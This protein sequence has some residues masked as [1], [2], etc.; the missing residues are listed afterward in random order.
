MRRRVAATVGDKGG[1]ITRRALLGRGSWGVG[2]RSFEERPEARSLGNDD[3]ESS[4]RPGGPL[5]AQKYSLSGVLCTRRPGPPPFSRPSR[6]NRPRSRDIEIVAHLVVDNCSED[7]LGVW[8]RDRWMISRRRSIRQ[9]ETD[10]TWFSMM[11]RA[12]SMAAEKRD[13]M[14]A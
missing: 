2:E 13:E 1:M 11:P 8:M 4:R 5:P 10:G 9:P 7:E 12:P 3:V 6:A 14:A